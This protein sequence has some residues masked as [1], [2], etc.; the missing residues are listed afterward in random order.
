MLGRQVPGRSVSG[1]GAHVGTHALPVERQVMREAGQGMAGLGRA[2][3]LRAVV[4]AA[5]RRAAL[6][7]AAPRFGHRALWGAARPAAN[8]CGRWRRR[9]RG[10]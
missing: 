1:I 10:G 6:C 5:G 3:L 4:S 2:W 7:C 8:L 9:W